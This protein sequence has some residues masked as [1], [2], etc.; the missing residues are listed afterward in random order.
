MLRDTVIE[1]LKEPSTLT[2]LARRL[3]RSSAE[4]RRVLS[5]LEREGGVCS[6]TIGR[7]RIYWAR[8][9]VED[10]SRDIRDRVRELEEE[11]RRL[12]EENERLR[13]E[14]SRP[15]KLDELWE[16]LEEW[17]AYAFKLADFIAYH[18]GKTVKEVLR[19]TGAPLDE[20]E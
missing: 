16:K 20:E 4:V 10:V 19:E 5:K 6:K 12:R 13:E 9:V 17:K 14:L 7:M 18:Q 3:K 1:A 2:E 15:G 11:V 8:V